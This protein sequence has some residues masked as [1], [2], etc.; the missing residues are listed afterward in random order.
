VEVTQDW[1]PGR[2]I[3]TGSAGAR[4]VHMSQSYEAATKLTAGVN[5]PF[6]GDLLISASHNFNGAG[7]IVGLNAKRAL[8]NSG[9]SLYGNSRATILFGTG[10]EVNSYFASEGVGNSIRENL[11]SRQTDVLPILE[12][13]FGGE[14]GKRIGRTYAFAQVGFVSQV[15]FG[16]G[17]ATNTSGIF[18]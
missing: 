11:T 5:S 7:P 1:R 13:E 17:N 18:N 14:Y 16:G 10:K 12:M 4:Y 9:L 8:G 15:W 2:W 6:D 3:L